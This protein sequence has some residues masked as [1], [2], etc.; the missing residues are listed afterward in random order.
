MTAR[1]LAHLVLPLLAALSLAGCASLRERLSTGGSKSQRDIISPKLRESLGGPRPDASAKPSGFSPA[2]ITNRPALPATNANVKA[3][4]RL[5]ANDPVVIFLRDLPGGR[6]QQ[7]EDIVDD[8]GTVNLPF[9]GRMVAMGKTSSEFEQEIE[10]KY[11]D[12][13]I[14]LRITV[15]VVTPQQF[16]FV[17]GEVKLPNKYQLVSGMTLSQAIAA[18]GSYTEYKERRKVQLIRGGRVTLYNMEQIEQNPALDPA[19]EPGD[20]VVVPRGIW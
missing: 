3:P 12:D 5:R 19:M 16:I 15:N 14:Y 10:K 2:T 6:E 18:A 9:I 7:L 1:R 20:Q 8:A 17:N 11:I 13:K 4:Y